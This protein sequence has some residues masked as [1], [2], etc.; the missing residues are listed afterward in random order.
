MRETEKNVSQAE[1]V[2]LAVLLDNMSKGQLPE[3]ILLQGR[4]RV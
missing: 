3:N 2:Q 1:P 4:S